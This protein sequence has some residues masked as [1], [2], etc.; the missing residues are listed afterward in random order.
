MLFVGGGAVFASM[1]VVIVLLVAVARGSKTGAAQPQASASSRLTTLPAAS[2]P[3]IELSADPPVVN[4]ESLPSGTS[5]AAKNPPK[6]NGKL[7][8]SAGP[9]W[10]NVTV[11]GKAQGATPVTDIE[12]ASGP[13][14]VKCV[15]AAGKTESMIVTIYPGGTTKHKFSVEP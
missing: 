7:W 11:D 6:G 14:T 15:S 3:V 1:I 8:V 2:S 13:H 4:V 12:L 10:C 9:G 5:T